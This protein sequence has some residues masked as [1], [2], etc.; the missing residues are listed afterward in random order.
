MQV[1]QITKLQ[2]ITFCMSS[3]MKKITASSAIGG[4]YDSFQKTKKNFD[5]TKNIN[6]FYNNLCI[7]TGI[8]SKQNI[9][10]YI[11]NLINNTN[12]NEEEAISILN[13]LSEFASYKSLKSIERELKKRKI[14]RIVE[15]EFFTEVGI[16]SKE[17]N[18]NNV[19]EY[20]FKRN[21]LSFKNYPDRDSNK[22]MILDSKLLKYLESLNNKNFVEWQNYIKENNIKLLYIN[23]FENS[24]NF[25]NQ[26]DSLDKFAI[27]IINSVNQTDKRA[28]VEQIKTF[29]NRENI[30]TITKLNLDVDFIN[31]ESKNKNNLQSI[32]NKVN[33]IIPTKKD[34]IDFVIKNSELCGVEKL[35]SQ[36]YIMQF[37]EKMMIAISPKEYNS[38]LK[39]L[40][41]QINRFVE[42]NNKNPENIYYLI[43][44]E[45][46]SFI[47]ANYQYAKV[48]NLKNLK[49]IYPEKNVW[50]NKAFD[51]SK[52]PPDSTVVVIDDCSISGLSLGQ[53]VFPYKNINYKNTDKNLS[54]LIAPLLITE[55]GLENIQ[56]IS[57]R[58]L[59][60]N[61]DKI[62]YQRIIPNWQSLDM[63]SDKK[64]LDMQNANDYV[65]SLVLPYMGP[66]T[67]C[68][69]LSPIYKK[70]FYSPKAQKFS[71]DNLSFYSELFL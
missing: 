35:K 11:D 38:Y 59:R 67:N 3:N 50:A 52:L 36:E 26:T 25:L 33:P 22:A 61:K 71:I 14:Q 30:E 9:K 56:N 51:L 49:Y 70:F 15:P 68:E 39:N 27:N 21:L 12:L 18:L 42:E 41:T 64:Y 2:P 20:I 19:L 7:N 48:N 29:L 60:H 17:P 31:I 23:N 66:D 44:S 37:L 58:I 65:T 6:N 5:V 34:F 47:I 62:L 43:P 28:S 46:K 10:I 54:M 63:L 40:H 53:D 8:I 24:Y 55:Q 16:S 69:F 4:V 13:I 45:N 57:K 32:A 1:Q